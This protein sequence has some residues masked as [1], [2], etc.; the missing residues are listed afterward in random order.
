MITLFPQ[1][2]EKRQYYPAG[3]KGTGETRLRKR[4]RESQDRIRRHG[5]HLFQSSSQCKSKLMRLTVPDARERLPVPRSNPEHRKNFH[6]NLRRLLIPHIKQLQLSAAPRYT[7]GSWPTSDVRAGSNPEWGRT[8]DYRG[9]NAWRSREPLQMLKLA[10]FLTSDIE[11]T[12]SHYLGK[13][14]PK[15]SQ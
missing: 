9:Y 12:S 8:S 15:A 4:S 2:M 10:T 3:G 13:T 7:R 1:F 5:M 11:A 6:A 14:M